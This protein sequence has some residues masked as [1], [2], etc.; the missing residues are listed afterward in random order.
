MRCSLLLPRGAR[1]GLPTLSGWAGP[2]SDREPEGD[3]GGASLL[4]PRGA[5][6]GLLILSGRA[7]PNS[8]REPEAIEND[9]GT[10]LLLPLLLVPLFY[11]VQLATLL[12]WLCRY[13]H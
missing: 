4:L 10:S 8:G 9:S 6:A 2:D 1:A 11:R 3:G 12:R 5:R 7:G 13:S